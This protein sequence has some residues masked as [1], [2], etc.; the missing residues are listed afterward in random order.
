MNLEYIKKHMLDKLAINPIIDPGY[1]NE[2][3]Y[4][5][6][7]LYNQIVYFWEN[8]NNNENFKKLISGDWD[9]I[10]LDG[11]RMYYLSDDKLID[12]IFNYT[13][14]ELNI[15]ID[16]YQDMLFN[17][18]ELSDNLLDKYNDISV[19]RNIK[20]NK[21]I[22]P[23]PTE[24][25]E[26]EPKNIWEKFNFTDDTNEEFIPYIIKYK[27]REIPDKYECLKFIG[28]GINNDPIYMIKSLGVRIPKN[29]EVVPNLEDIFKK[30]T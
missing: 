16:E 25:V 8:L 17:S 9:N 30:V 26:K 2:D 18:T 20:I 28:N 6:K 12:M 1:Y 29:Y 24:K 3:G 10:D 14:D 7:D 13:Y 4:C 15:S 19:K 27:S 11:G 23:A 22:D 21:M 5:A